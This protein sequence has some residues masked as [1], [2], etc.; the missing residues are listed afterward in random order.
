M[1]TREISV[2]IPTY[3]GLSMLRETL[4]SLEK[5][6]PDP[7]SF[8][9]VVVDDCSTDGTADFLQ[10]Y[11]GNLRLRPVLQPRNSG[12]AAARNA[13]VRAAECEL[14]LFIDGD[15]RFGEGL[16]GGHVAQHQ[17]I[18]QVVLGKVVYDKS[19]PCKGYRRY[20]ETRGANKLPPGTALPGR[21]FWSGHVS[22]PKKMFETIGGFD[23]KFNVHG[24]EDIDF[25]MRIAA[26]GFSMVHVPELVVEHLHVRNLGAVATTAREY[27]RSAVPI[28]V[29]KHPELYRQLRLD[30]LEGAGISVWMKRILLTE[31]VYK[32]VF[33]IASV[34]N[35][36]AAPSKMYDYLIFRS[37]YTGFRES[38]KNFLS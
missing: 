37:Y 8:Q 10:S 36:L 30:W 18:E 33:F 26:G 19:L 2:V 23:E 21:F 25:G 31:P 12:R 6:I 17:D 32:L 27:G 22:M 38:R 9:T 35:D 7:G 4:V 15:M 3:N 11:S 16:V 29:E 34:L 24:G 1:Q 5:Q 28:L 14:L 20:I 13:G